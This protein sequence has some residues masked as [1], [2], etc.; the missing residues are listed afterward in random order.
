MIYITK[1]NLIS[2]AFE[3]FIDE[4]SQ[5][6]ANVLDEVEMENIELI[7]GYIASRYG[8]DEIFSPLL[9]IKN[10]ILERI[11]KKLVLFD[12]IRRNAGRKV[13]T[14]YKEEYDK[15]IELLEKISTGRIKL[16]GLPSPTDN[17]GN[18]IESTS[19][20]GNTTN[21]NLYI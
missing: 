9:P 7:K 19:L 4:S 1:E 20:W 15:A 6:H 3:R 16:E 10:V 2:G 18:P 13:P 8:V 17:N 12:L 5:D 11:L 21:K 14:D